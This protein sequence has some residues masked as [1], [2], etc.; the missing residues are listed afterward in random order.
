MKTCFTVFSFYNFY[1]LGWWAWGWMIGR[2]KRNADGM[3]S[4]CSNENSLTWVQGEVLRD[5]AQ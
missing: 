3:T 4:Y 1:H 2:G 5:Q